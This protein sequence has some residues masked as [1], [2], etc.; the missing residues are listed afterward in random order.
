MG[1][2]EEQI[3]SLVKNKNPNNPLAYVRNIVRPLSIDKLIQCM[4]SCNDCSIGNNVRSLPYGNY[5]GSILIVRDFVSKEYLGKKYVYAYNENNESDAAVKQSIEQYGINTKQILW[6][7]AV[8][9]CPYEIIGKRTCSRIPNKTELCN[10]K[11]FVDFA[12]QS[13]APVFIFLMGAT[14]L[15]MF[16]DIGI[17]EM[18][19]HFVSLHGIPAMPVYSPEYLQTVKEKMPDSYPIC[20]KVFDN[21]IERASMFLRQRYPILFN[22]NVKKESVF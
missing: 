18:H 20:K 22:S 12:I 3:Y 15:S 8:N 4:K 21:D 13:F 1:A 19:G 14:A 5:N 11:V 7:N 2:I 6:M 16:I 17:N 9:C 10:C